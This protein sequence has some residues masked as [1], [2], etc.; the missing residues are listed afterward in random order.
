[1]QQNT[2]LFRTVAVLVG[3][4]ALLF[5][6]VEF[7][8]ARK[9]TYETYSAQQ[10]AAARGPAKFPQLGLPEKND[11]L[12]GGETNLK[13]IPLGPFAERNY[14][15]ASETEKRKQAPLFLDRHMPLP[16]CQKASEAP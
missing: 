15:R 13:A 2:L 16:N 14:C 7:M 1:M 5:I 4:A 8:T 6:Y 9:L 10:E 11:I 3:I 12:A